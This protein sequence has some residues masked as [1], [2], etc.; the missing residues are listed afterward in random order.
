MSWNQELTSKMATKKKK[1][2]RNYKREYARDQSSKKA[3][4][5]RAKRN[6]IRRKLTRKGVVKKG[7]GKEV[8]H[9]KGVR[10]GNGKKNIR[11][12]SRRTNRKIGKK[13]K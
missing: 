3:K 8:H 5:D 9:V 4:T 10:K 7:D 6:K 11:V 1:K 12:V 13:R 2:P